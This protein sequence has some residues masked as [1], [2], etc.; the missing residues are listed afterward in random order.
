MKVLNIHS[1]N[2]VGIPVSTAGKLR[3]ADPLQ[4][5][6]V[7]SFLLFFLWY[8]S[9]KTCMPNT[10]SRSSVGQIHTVGWLSV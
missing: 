10:Y 7:L 9:L 2:E 6:Q 3:A 4:Y 8:C 5:S 1:A